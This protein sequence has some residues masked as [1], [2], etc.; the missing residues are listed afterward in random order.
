MAEHVRVEE[1][2]GE[3]IED[4]HPRSPLSVYTLAMAHLVAGILPRGSSAGPDR[5]SSPGTTYL[6]PSGLIYKKH[7][8][9]CVIQSDGHYRF[10]EVFLGVDTVRQCA[11]AVPEMLDPIV[12]LFVCLFYF[13]KI[14]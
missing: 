7:P 9:L 3:E 10:R 12:C 5:G 1:V 8:A 2:V 13:C 14:A 11:G 4:V 6:P